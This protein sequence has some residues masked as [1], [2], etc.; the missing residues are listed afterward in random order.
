MIRS[1]GRSA[2]RIT[3]SQFD[4]KLF[5]IDRQRRGM[6]LLS[7]VNP[8]LYLTYAI[9]DCI[10]GAFG[11]SSNL[12]ID[13]RTGGNSKERD[14]NSL[15]AS[16]V[17]RLI[18]FGYYYDQLL[19]ILSIL[20]I[21]YL[22]MNIDLYVSTWRMIIQSLYLQTHFGTS[23]MNLFRNSWIELSTEGLNPEVLRL[24]LIAGTE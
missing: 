14:C 24:H 10:N 1:I 4:A 18:K 5:R 23:E 11:I 21:L 22:M 9:N 13:D 3:T 19:M 7:C 6:I 8:A 2:T 17:V 16:S 20:N 15:K 12:T